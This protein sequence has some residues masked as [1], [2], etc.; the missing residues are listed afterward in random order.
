M[1]ATW[2]LSPSGS[3]NLQS[4][5]LLTLQVHLRKLADTERPVNI[6]NVTTRG[7]PRDEFQ[8]YRMAN[9]AYMLYR[10]Q[11]CVKRLFVDPLEEI[12]HS[13]V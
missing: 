9:L 13:D 11:K 6:A 2:R 4:K 10:V 5:V 7:K 3:R 12:L 1:R 8:R